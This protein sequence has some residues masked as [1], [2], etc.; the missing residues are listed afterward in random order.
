MKRGQTMILSRRLSLGV[1]SPRISSQSMFI[2]EVALLAF[3]GTTQQ[4]NH[5][6]FTWQIAFASLSRLY[7]AQLHSRRYRTHRTAA[8]T[9]PGQRPLGT[10]FR[11]PQGAN[12]L[13][14]P[15]G[16]RA[17]WGNEGA[18]DRVRAF[19][20]GSR[21]VGERANPGQFVPSRSPTEPARAC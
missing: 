4:S 17:F 10:R 2:S 14:R 13:L 3:V 21:E 16:G 19:K 18:A 11:T 1:R 5:R 9:S 8:T 6:K 12:P 15:I 20:S 7:F